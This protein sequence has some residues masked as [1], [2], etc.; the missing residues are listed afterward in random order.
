MVKGFAIIF[1]LMHHLF[2]TSPGYPLYA[3]TYGLNKIANWDKL[4]FFSVNA[5]VCVGMFVFLSAFGITR[6]YNKKLAAN[7][8]AIKLLQKKIVHDA[9]KRYVNLA[10]NYFFIYLIAVLTFGLRQDELKMVYQAQGTMR[11]IMYIIF[12]ILGVASFFG[13]PT[14]NATWWYMAVAIF[15]IFLIPI[16]IGMYKDNG[17]LLVIAAVFINYF[18]DVDNSFL[19]IFFCV[20][21]GICCAEE[22]II[23]KITAFH[24]IKYS[25]LNAIIKVIGY[26]FFIV[27]LFFIRGKTS[28]AYYIDAL[29]TLVFCCFCMELNILLPIISKPISFLGKYSMNMFFIH[30]LI[31]YYYF[32][33]FIYGFNNWILI[34]MALIITSLLGSVIIE[35]VKRIIQYPKLTDRIYRITSNGSRMD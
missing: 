32:T 22:E 30:T 16:I 13:T 33:E 10:M 5:K 9:V 31:Y 20:I 3:E 12:D 19:K 34:T 29:L 25:K 11:A 27:A 2:G 7:P 21:F 1:M 28:Y 6:T 4:L 18:V 15:L 8:G 17:M 26:L 24:L 14:L 23:E 35:K